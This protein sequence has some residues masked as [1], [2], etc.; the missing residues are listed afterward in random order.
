MRKKNTNFIE[1]LSNPQ[2]NIKDS[3]MFPEREVVSKTISYQSTPPIVSEGSM[4]GKAVKYPIQS[5][6]E[7]VLR[8]RNIYD[9]SSE[10]MMKLKETID[11]LT[12]L[13]KSK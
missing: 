4:A 13:R 1:G 7:M 6:D 5:L 12:R 3:L 8:E 2:Q 10:Q 11:D 9:K